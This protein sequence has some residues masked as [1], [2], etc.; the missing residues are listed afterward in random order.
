MRSYMKNMLQF[1]FTGS[2]LMLVNMSIAQ[3]GKY[4][5]QFTI[6]KSADCLLGEAYFDIEIKAADANSTFRISD[7]NYRFSFNR[8]ALANPRII[9]EFEIGGIIDEGP[10]AFSLYSEHSLNGSVD[11]VVSYGFELSGGVGYFIGEED[12]I[13]VGR[14]GFDIMDT[15]ACVELKW[16]D[17]NTFPSTFIGEIIN[18]DLYVARENSFTNFEGCISDICQP[19]PIEL[20][21]FTGEEKD[22]RIDL[23]WQ[24]QTETNSSHFIVQESSD[25]LSFSDLERV[26]AAGFSAVLLTYN[27]TDEIS[28]VYNYYRLKQVDL[29]GSYEYSKMIRVASDCYEP[30]IINGITDLYPNPTT[31][32]RAVRVHVY[33]DNIQRSA[34]LVLRAISGRIIYEK[35]IALDGGANTVSFIPENL[36]AGMYLLQIKSDDWFS[37]PQKLVLT[38]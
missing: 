5:I 4:D 28:G 34:E 13:P 25:G 22:C 16:H 18:S 21:S 9:E 29:D 14:V 38:E 23:V 20:T 26:E 19:L 12:W 27:F 7:Q 33:T 17:S 36:P 31:N 15:T 2:L 10:N 3:T 1:M 8:K 32:G 30:D 35:N 24:T 6:G 11:T 37:K